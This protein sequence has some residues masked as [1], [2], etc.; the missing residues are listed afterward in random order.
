MDEA[1]FTVFFFFVFSFVCEN[2]TPRPL[3]ALGKDCQ[4]A[5]NAFTSN[6]S[7]TNSHYHPQLKVESTY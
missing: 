6:T 1:T 7:S 4:G 3:L 2:T 5:G